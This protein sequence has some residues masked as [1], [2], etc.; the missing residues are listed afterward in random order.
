MLPEHSAAAL[1]RR[2]MEQRSKVGTPKQNRTSCLTGAALR[3][4]SQPEDLLLPVPVRQSKMP[5]PAAAGSVLSKEADRR[6]ETCTLLRRAAAPAK[7]T[8]PMP[9]YHCAAAGHG[10]KRVCRFCGRAGPPLGCGSQPAGRKRQGS[11]PAPRQSR[12]WLPPKRGQQ[13]VGA[14]P[15][16]A[17]GGHH[18]T[19]DKNGTGIVLHFGHLVQEKSRKI[20][21]AQIAGKSMLLVWIIP[22]NVV[23]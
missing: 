13:L 6:E 20:H 14:K 15:L 12:P 17:A 22:K 4:P 7:R 11:P 18:Y 3:H 23:K 19:P 10:A 1:P 8:N 5:G 21:P 2:Q 9:Q 16:A